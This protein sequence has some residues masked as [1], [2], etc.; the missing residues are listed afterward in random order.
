[1]IKRIIAIAALL[2]LALPAMSARLQSGEGGPSADDAKTE[3]SVKTAS[4]NGKPRQAARHAPAGGNQSADE[5]LP[6]V[7]ETSPSLNSNSS[8]VDD[9]DE[10]GGATTLNE[11]AMWILGAALIVLMLG[12]HAF[13]IISVSN[14]KQELAKSHDQLHRAQR[15]MQKSLSSVYG[16]NS[17]TGAA[18]EKLSSQLDQQHQALGQLSAQL[19]E[20]RRRSAA[21]DKKLDNATTAIATSARLAGESRIQQEIHEAAGEMAESDRALAARIV[22]RYCEI[23]GA[24]SSRVKAL[25]QAM[26]ALDESLAGRSHLPADLV[27]RV[28]MLQQEICQ[29]DRW[30]ADASG[31]L[32]S[33]RGGSID[34]RLTAFRSN[35]RKVA[36]AFN[37][38]EISVIEFVK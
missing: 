4:K 15:D 26:S 27:G 13:H 24:N 14:V 34:V 9:R 5:I 28:H 19:E 18:L 10:T 31:R 35:E 7:R 2:S 36:E 6:D 11:P 3:A 37:L 25:A 8:P 21:A 17:P 16:N 30:H 1:M 20:L 22:E 12:M 23:F 38:G 29:F 33:L 32:S